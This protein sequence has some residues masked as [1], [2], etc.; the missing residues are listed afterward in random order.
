MGTVTRTGIAGFL[1][2]ATAEDVLRQ[3]DCSVL[4]VKPDGFVTPVAA[5][6]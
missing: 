2:G 5:S 3:V 1:I 6:D 4:T